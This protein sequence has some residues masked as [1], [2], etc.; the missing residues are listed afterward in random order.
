M[1]EKRF[2]GANP[3]ADL[4]VPLAGTVDLPDFA[5][6]VS[7]A[8]DAAGPSIEAPRSP[9]PVFCSKARREGSKIKESAFIREMERAP[10][11]PHS[12]TPKSRGFV[13]KFCSDASRE[14]LR[15]V[16][17]G[18]NRSVSRP[19]CGA[20]RASCGGFQVQLSDCT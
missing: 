12:G 19:V 17:G 14:F 5:F 3:A 11:I 9:K 4:V 16:S 13:R 18:A 7:A 6:G 1:R 20:E 2:N 10:E 8:E 15:G